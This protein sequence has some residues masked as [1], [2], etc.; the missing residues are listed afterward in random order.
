MDKEKEKVVE[1]KV[2]FAIVVV[3]TEKLSKLLLEQDKELNKH[4]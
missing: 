3:T 2:I 4:K 1:Q